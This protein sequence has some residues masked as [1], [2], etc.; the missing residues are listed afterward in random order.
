MSIRLLSE[1]AAYTYILRDDYYID[2]KNVQMMPI[3]LGSLQ[4]WKVQLY[5][6]T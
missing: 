1:D 3:H 5:Y 6:F 4:D 2:D